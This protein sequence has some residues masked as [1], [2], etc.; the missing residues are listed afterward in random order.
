VDIDADLDPAAYGEWFNL[1]D[2]P[3]ARVESRTAPAI[4]ANRIE[5]F[6]RGLGITGR[7]LKMMDR[8][9]R[10]VVSDAE[11]EWRDRFFRDRGL[12]GLVV[13]VQP[14]TDEAYRDVPHMGEIVEALVREASV[15]VF[16]RVPVSSADPRLVQAEGLTIRE[17]FALAS[18]CDVLVTPDS[19]FFHLAGALDLPCVGL[20]GPTDGRVRGHD[21]PRARTLD[22]RRTLACVP[23]WRNEATA[24]ALTG[25]RPSA[26]LGEIAPADV[27][28]AVRDAA[29]T[30]S[31]RR[32]VAD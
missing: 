6:A 11:L 9:P 32:R 16:G 28:L 2:C 29:A 3:A 24:C 31:R 25:M 18:G 1:T 4:K 30:T 27:V 12:D 17:A 22:A 26:C 23:C 5:L 10:Y 19:A 20:F 21:Y 14:H 13:G 7:R 8:R 15:L